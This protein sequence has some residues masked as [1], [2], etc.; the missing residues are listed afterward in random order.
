MK[1]EDEDLELTEK[2]YYLGTGFDEEGREYEGYED[3]ISM[4]VHFYY[5]D[6]GSELE[7]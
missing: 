4:E 6:D 1:L 3:P 7:D 2:G 5:V